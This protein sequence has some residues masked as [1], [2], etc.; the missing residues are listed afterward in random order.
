MLG[1]LARHCYENKTTIHEE[2]HAQES[3]TWRK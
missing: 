3:K 1:E 2:E